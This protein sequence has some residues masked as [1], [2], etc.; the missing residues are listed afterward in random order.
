MA[1]STRNLSQSGSSGR[2]PPAGAKKPLGA[3]S[4]PTTSTVSTMPERIWERAVSMARAPDA[5]AAYTLVTRAPC[6]PS[7]RAKVAPAT[8]P[9]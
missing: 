9:G 8:C 1:P 5:Q 7:A 2:S 3:A 4:A 6:Q